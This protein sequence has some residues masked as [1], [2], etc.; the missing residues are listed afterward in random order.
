VGPVPE[1]PSLSSTSLSTSTSSG[2]TTAAT[3]R[4]SDKTTSLSALVHDWERS[5]YAQKA[6]LAI[7][8]L[9]ISLQ[10]DRGNPNSRSIQKELEIK[11]QQFDAEKAAMQGMQDKFLKIEAGS[12]LHEQALKELK[13]FIHLKAT[14]SH[15]LWSYCI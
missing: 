4:S 2:T 13:A 9:K 1:G 8:A 14:G 15:F 6:A 11:Q 5:E 3:P 12:G 10:T 7:Q